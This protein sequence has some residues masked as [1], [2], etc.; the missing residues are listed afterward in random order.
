VPGRKLHVPL[1]A[2]AAADSVLTIARAIA[3][4]GVTSQRPS[5]C[6]HT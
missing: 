4:S 5:T 3:T 2:A 6:S 1:L